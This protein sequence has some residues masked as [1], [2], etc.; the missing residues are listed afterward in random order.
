MPMTSQKPYL[1]PFL[2]ESRL[3]P[4]DF[5]VLA[6]FH[7]CS[8]DPDP[9]EGPDPYESAGQID[10]IEI[11]NPDML[12]VPR[13]IDAAGLTPDEFRI[14]Y[15]VTCK[16]TPDAPCTDSI[17]KISRFT[18]IRQQQVQGTVGALVEKGYLYKVEGSGLRAICHAPTTPE[19]LLCEQPPEIPLTVRQE[20]K[21]H[22]PI[23]A[24]NRAP[25]EFTT[26][27]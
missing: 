6:H 23:L 5:R 1:H 18:E 24:T 10:S 4:T 7:R 26:L 27:R 11:S 8:E 9:Y 20:R 13:W 2:N 17:K 25:V 16:E 14:F 21:P 19:T 3:S 15:Y 12:V 22:P